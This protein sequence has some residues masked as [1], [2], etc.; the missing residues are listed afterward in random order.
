MENAVLFCIMDTSG[1]MG[2]TKKTLSRKYYHMFKG[3][4]DGRYDNVGER[5]IRYTTIAKEV[6]NIIELTNRVE[7]GGTYTSSGVSKALEIIEKDIDT[8]KTDVYA[9]IFSDGDNWGK[10]NETMVEQ[11]NKLCQL[12]NGV[13]FVEVKISTYISTI[14]EKL[15]NEVFEPT[16]KSLSIHTKNDIAK[17]LHNMYNQK[18]TKPDGKTLKNRDNDRLLTFTNVLDIIRDSKKT[19]VILKDGSYGFA[20][21]S[22]Q[23]RYDD[24]IGFTIARLRAE[25]ESNKK[26]LKNLM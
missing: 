7:N 10:D 23:D 25:I 5:F 3:M 14:R 2:V 21:C 15:D 20:V 8:Q 11:T 1:S 17:L 26:A 19:T 12:C 16:Y 6:D 24:E 22:Q 4:L 9:L 18:F 13:E